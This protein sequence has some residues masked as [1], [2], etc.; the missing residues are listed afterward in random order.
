M[1]KF[2][3]FVEIG[4]DPAHRE[5]FDDVMMKHSKRTLAEEQGCLK[6]DVYVSRE[7]PNRYGL[8]EVFEDEAALIVH[9]SS[10]RLSGYREATDPIVVS[11]NVWSVG[12]LVDV[13][14]LPGIPQ[15]DPD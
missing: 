6:F 10:D 15:P 13:T 12:E 1:P 14:K 3:F 8:Y 4:V 2:A 7:D 5:E 11:E 9:T